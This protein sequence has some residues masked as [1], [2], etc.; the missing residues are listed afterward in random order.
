VK[1]RTHGKAGH[2]HC[3]PALRHPAL[4]DDPTVRTRRR[5]DVPPSRTCPN[6]RWYSAF[7]QERPVDGDVAP[8]GAHPSSF[9]SGDDP[10]WGFPAPGEVLRRLR[11][12]AG[13]SLRDVASRS[14]LSQSFLGQLERG[15]TDIALERLAR[16]ARVFGHDVGSFLG[17]SARRATPVLL[18]D[19]RVIVPRGDGIQYEVIRLPGLGS[20]L[21]FVRLEPQSRFSAELT[22]EGI[23]V[24]LVVEGTVCATYNHEEYVLKTGDC[25]LWSGGYPHSFRNDTKKRACYVGL[26]TAN[27]F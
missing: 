24:T 25:M 8:T 2:P 27:V 4:R 22:H 17:F 26:V 5:Q 1:Y 12:Q 10:E 13:Y 9:E 23:D 6:Q 18:D 14:G 16:L 21:V 19:T 15:E 11:T 3:D 7:V 20:E